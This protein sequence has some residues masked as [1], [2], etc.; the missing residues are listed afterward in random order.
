MRES[1][2]FSKLLFVTPEVRYFVND[3][4]RHIQSMHTCF[5]NYSCKIELSDNTRKLII[6][7]LFC[8]RE[9]VYFVIK[10]FY[11]Y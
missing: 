6:I 1:C 3:F 10:L 11:A 4:F 9:T 8:F 2:L 5:L 7:S